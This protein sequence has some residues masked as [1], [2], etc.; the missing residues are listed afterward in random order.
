MPYTIFV[1]NWYSMTKEKYL[2]LREAGINQFSPNRLIN[3]FTRTNTCDECYMSI[4]SNL[5]KTYSQR[6]WENVVGFFS[7]KP[8]VK[9]VPDREVAPA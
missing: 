3:E 2:A 6:L 5:D 9:R 8:R 7:F 1:S 4:R